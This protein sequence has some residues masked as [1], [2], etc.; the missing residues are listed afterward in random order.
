M[1]ARRSHKWCTLLQLGAY[2][3]TCTKLVRMDEFALKLH[4]YCALHRLIDFKGQN[5]GGPRTDCLFA[6]GQVLAQFLL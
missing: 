4:R 3:R 6:H 2:C 1:M 5:A